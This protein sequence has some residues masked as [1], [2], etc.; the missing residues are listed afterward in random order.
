MKW[1]DG[2]CILLLTAILAFVFVTYLQNLSFP[3]CEC[4]DP[5][6]YGCSC[7]NWVNYCFTKN[8]TENIKSCIVGENEN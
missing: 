1:E 6:K 8:G 7:R 5:T 2:V 4:V 3:S